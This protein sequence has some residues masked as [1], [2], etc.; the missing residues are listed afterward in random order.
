ML[1]K[2]S[3]AVTPLLV[4]EPVRGPGGSAMLVGSLRGAVGPADV[5]PRD[6]LQTARLYMREAVGRV[7][8][9]T[10]CQ[11]GVIFS[12]SEDVAAVYVMLQLKVLFDRVGGDQF[13][14]I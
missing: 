9:P 10:T 12:S 3:V 4:T 5:K 6:T 2:S 7:G 1:Q 14:C 11:R 8:G 13:S